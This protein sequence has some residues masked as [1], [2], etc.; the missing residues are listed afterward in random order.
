MLCLIKIYVI[1]YIILFRFY[2]YLFLLIKYSFFYFLKNV[3]VICI[4][5]IIISCCCICKNIYMV[6]DIFKIV[7]KLI[8]FFSVNFFYKFVLFLKCFKF[9]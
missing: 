2:K 5:M 6:V 9:I 8:R 3:I 4:C 1:G 7:F